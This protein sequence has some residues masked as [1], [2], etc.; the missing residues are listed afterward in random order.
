MPQ[1]QNVRMEEGVKPRTDGFLGNAKVDHN[2][3]TFDYITELHSYLWRVVRLA[4]GQGAGGNLSEHVDAAI[5]KLEF[6]ASKRAR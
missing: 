6:E 5:G 1:V 4:F 3:E 2:S